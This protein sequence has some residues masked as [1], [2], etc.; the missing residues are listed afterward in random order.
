M[1]FNKIDSDIL[2]VSGSVEVQKIKILS[3]F[4]TKQ[5]ILFNCTALITNIQRL[6][7]RLTVYCNQ[8]MYLHYPQLDTHRYKAKHRLNASVNNQIIQPRL[9]RSVG[10]SRSL[11]TVDAS[12]AAISFNPTK[13]VRLLALFTYGKRVILCRSH[14]A[15]PKPRACSIQR[16]QAMFDFVGSSYFSCYM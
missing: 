12:S 16:C 3:K 2:G 5:L 14:A 6:L 8:Y 11:A 7:I 4:K 1:F 13:R 15:H 10:I 9:R